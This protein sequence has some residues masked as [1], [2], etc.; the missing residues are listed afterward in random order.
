MIKKCQFEGCGVEFEG[1][2]RALYCPTHRFLLQKEARARYEEKRDRARANAASLSYYYRHREE[3][4]AKQ[5]AR[6]KANYEYKRGPNL[7]REDLASW[8]IEYVRNG[9]LWT[10]KATKGNVTL[11]AHRNFYSLRTAQKDCAYAL[12]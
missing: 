6:N 12:G 11:E 10:W 7:E 4:L 3:C 9:D 1:G 2:Y 8:K 5:K